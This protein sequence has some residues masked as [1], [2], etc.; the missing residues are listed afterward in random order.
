[1]ILSAMEDHQAERVIV[2]LKDFRDQCAQV[3]EGAKIPM[4]VFAIPCE[5]V[6]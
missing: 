6:I 2:R 1:M 3:Q 5:R 4:R